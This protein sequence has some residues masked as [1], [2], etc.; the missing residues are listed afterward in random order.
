MMILNGRQ[1]ANRRTWADALC[2][3]RQG[4]RQLALDD[5]SECCIGVGC[6]VLTR[7]PRCEIAAYGTA[8][9]LPVDLEV[10]AGVSRAEARTLMRANDS[11][12]D[13]ARQ[14]MSHA[15]IASYLYLTAEAGL[16]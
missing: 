1:I 2:S 14:G 7:I 9:A 4:Y 10:L 13:G 12:Q 15:E 6:R 5:G 11:H 8:N 3:S 16:A